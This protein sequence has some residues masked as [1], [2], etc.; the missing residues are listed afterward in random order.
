MPRSRRDDRFLIVSPSDD[1]P[2]RGGRGPNFP[3]TNL[4]SRDAKPVQEIENNRGWRGID[5]VPESPLFHPRMIRTA[6]RGPYLSETTP[7]AGWR[8][9]GSK[10]SMGSWLIDMDAQD[11]QDYLARDSTVMSSPIASVPTQISQKP[12]PGSWITSNTHPI[13]ERICFLWRSVSCCLSCLSCASM[14][15]K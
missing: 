13:I 10:S 3:E 4:G 8:A 9:T 2:R 14:F 11:A 15:N 6:G 7:C 5:N 1:P 12:L